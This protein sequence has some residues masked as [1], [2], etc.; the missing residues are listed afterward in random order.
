MF[1]ISRHTT[2]RDRI[3]IYAIVA[4]GL[5]LAACSTENVEDQG[6]LDGRPEV[7]LQ[8]VPATRATNNLSDGL[9]KYGTTFYAWAD[10]IHPT[11][12]ANNV[13]FD[14]VYAYAGIQAWR[15]IAKGD[16]QGNLEASTRRS[17]PSQD[18]LN[19][20][21]VHGNFDGNTIIGNEDA[22]TPVQLVSGSTPFPAPKEEPA[23]NTNFTVGFIHTVL[24]DQRS[25]NTDSY[26]NSDLL[27]GTATG[28]EPRPV[29][30]NIKAYHMLS[31]IEVV[32]KEGYK[33]SMSILQNENVTLE[34]AGTTPACLF[35]P[36][37]LKAHNYNV[38]NLAD[39][40]KMIQPRGSASN[41]KMNKVVIEADKAFSDTTGAKVIVVPT[42]FEQATTLIEIHMN[43]V[44]GTED[45]IAYK[46]PAG[47]E[48]KS[49]YTYR[50]NLIINDGHEIILDPTYVAPN[51]DY[52]SQDI[53]D[54][55]SDG[56]AEVNISKVLEEATEQQEIELDP[57]SVDW[58]EENR[59]LYMQ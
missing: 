47:F 25:T 8:V 49:G 41:I 59:D 54:S 42:K 6:F 48:L 55:D 26:I 45:V 10:A 14:S 2:M 1:N 40:A 31:R 24:D 52:E 22:G 53:H 30:V 21:L 43:G 34:I 11:V 51:N 5:L 46:V 3:K 15:L 18:N 19:F 58:N 23:P 27:F 37:T 17:F 36:D 38:A 29:P 50:F 39:R 7:K 20:Y 13:L 32:L 4:G 9:L 33:A 35:S 57:S 56:W 12:D 16:A 44:N 28:V